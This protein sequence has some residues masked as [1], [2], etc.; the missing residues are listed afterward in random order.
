MVFSY[1]FKSK[2]FWRRAWQYFS[3]SLFPFGQTYRYSYIPLII[4]SSEDK[5]QLAK[6]FLKSGKIVRAY[7]W[8]LIASQDPSPY[9]C[10][11]KVATNSAQDLRYQVWKAGLMPQAKRFYERYRKIVPYLSEM[12]ID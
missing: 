7:V 2:V 9:A 1:K 12:Q 6:Q 10:Y 11:K 3:L 4:G 5:Y 8:F